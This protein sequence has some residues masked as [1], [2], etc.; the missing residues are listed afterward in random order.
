MAQRAPTA[1]VQAAGQRPPTFSGFVVRLLVYLFLASLVFSIGEL[2]LHMR[3]IQ[4]VMAA[5]SAWMANLFGAGVDRVEAPSSRRRTPR[6]RSTT[7]APACSCCSCTRCSSSPIRR[8]WPASPARHCDRLRTLTAI[9]VARL[10]V[11]DGDRQP[12][13]RL[14]RLLPRV[15]L[16]GTVHRA[17]GGAGLAVDRAGAPCDRPPAFCL[18]SSRWPAALFALW[19]FAGVGD[20]YGARRRRRRP[21]R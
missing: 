4:T 6:S 19:S 10:I 5:W 18:D 8:R 16:P 9:N 14:V 20:L 2:H 7:S 15:L 13:S 1:S 12:V 17:A 3:P 11:A 21:T